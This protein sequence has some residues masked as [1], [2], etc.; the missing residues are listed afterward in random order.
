MVKNEGN[1]CTQCPAFI[2]EGVRSQICEQAGIFAASVAL[3]HSTLAALAFFH[4]RF[5]RVHPFLDGNGRVGRTILAAQFEKVFGVLPA[6]T[7]QPGY[8]EAIRACD[9]RAEENPTFE[10]DLVWSRCRP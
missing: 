1:H 10:E 2:A 3:R 4:V 7:N 9:R 8:R 6:F 5:E